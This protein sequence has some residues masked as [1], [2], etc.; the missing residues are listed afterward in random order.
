L[1][2]F[3]GSASSPIVDITTGTHWFHA[4]V[5]GYEPGAGVGVLNMANLAAAIAR[6]AR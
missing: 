6:D 2:D 5:P 4:G 3:M 1:R